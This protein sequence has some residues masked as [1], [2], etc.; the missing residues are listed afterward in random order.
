MLDGR[1]N[2]YQAPKPSKRD[3]K[4]QEALTAFDQYVGKEIYSLRTYLFEIYAHESKRW[5]L[6]LRNF[7]IDFE[8]TGEKSCPLVGFRFDR[9][10]L[11]QDFLNTTVFVRISVA[12]SRER[13]DFVQRS[14]WPMYLTVDDICRAHAVLL[15]EPRVR[16]LYPQPAEDYVVGEA[17]W[18]SGPVDSLWTQEKLEENGIA[19]SVELQ[20]VVAVCVLY[21][22]IGVDFEQPI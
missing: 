5:W 20:H 16:Y 22:K 18:I 19:L 14:D 15:T 21:A 4:R 8:K 13:G 9:P 10:A 6:A 1:N 7:L 17:G 12:A 3:I 2:T 11:F